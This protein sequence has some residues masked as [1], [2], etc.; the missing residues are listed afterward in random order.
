MKRIKPST[1]PLINQIEQAN[2][3]ER[4]RNL[5]D[6][7]LDIVICDPPSYKNSVDKLMNNWNTESEYIQWF[8]LFMK[9][10]TSKLK[11]TGIFYLIGE[12]DEIH[13]LFAPVTEYGFQVA[14]TYYFIKH[15]KISSGRKMSENSRTQRVVDCVVVFTRDFQKKV[16]KLLKLKQ[17]ESRKTAREINV[18]LSG[19]GNGGGYWSLYCGDNSKNILPSEEH[20]NIL[21]NIFSIDLEYNDILTQF[22]P[23]EG[24][25][26]WEDIHYADDKFLN[27]TNRPVS[28]YERLLGMNR[29]N[30]ADI[31]VWDPFCGYGNSTL[32]C[33][34]KGVS[35]FANEYDMKTYYKAMINTGNTVNIVKPLNV[36]EI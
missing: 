12:L 23:Y 4:G 15:K 13:S 27:G 9:I 25:N 33:K 7:Q 18:E 17:E 2:A 34:K 31:V 36:Q 5:L 24:S 16:K 3:L 35:F 19:N 28:F 8:N 32:A 10:V 29:K 6:N 20:W 1:E 22:R 30:P 26:L 14:M 21:R 11:K